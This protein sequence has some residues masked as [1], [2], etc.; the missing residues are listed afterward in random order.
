MQLFVPIIVSI[1]WKEFLKK[2]VHLLPCLFK[3]YLHVSVPPSE[4]LLEILI[5]VNDCLLCDLV[6]AVTGDLMTTTS[7]FLPNFVDGTVS[8]RCVLV[9]Y[10]TIT[11]H[12]EKGN[13]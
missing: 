13:Y 8:D 3:D 9:L 12:P 1:Y 11:Q 5:L 7:L 2:V 10:I 4:D 6:S